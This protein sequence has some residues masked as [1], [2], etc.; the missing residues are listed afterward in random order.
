MGDSFPGPYFWL[1]A[2]TVYKTG[3]MLLPM[4]RQWFYIYTLEHGRGPKARFHF[5]SQHFTKPHLSLSYLTT[6]TYQP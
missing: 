6:S 4:D 2:S 3:R 5:Q 1:S